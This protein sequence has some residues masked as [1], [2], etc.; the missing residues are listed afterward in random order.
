MPPSSN[1]LPSTIQATKLPP[2]CTSTTPKT[3]P[4]QHLLAILP[5]RHAYKEN[6]KKIVKKKT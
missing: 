4:K 2:N 6:K 1:S 5:H 3:L